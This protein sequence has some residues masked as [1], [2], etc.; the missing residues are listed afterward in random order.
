MWLSIPRGGDGC[1]LGLFRLGEGGGS[2]MFLLINSYCWGGC[3]PGLLFG[4]LSVPGR[5]PTILV[6]ICVL[7]TCFINEGAR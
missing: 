5:L 7:M 4:Y 3:L 6:G 2:I 1:T